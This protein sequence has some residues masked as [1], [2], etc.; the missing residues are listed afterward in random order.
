MMRKELMSLSQENR[1]SVR[2]SHSQKHLLTFQNHRLE[3]N[4]DL[5]NISHRF[6]RFDDFRNLLYYWNYF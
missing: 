5:Q 3:Q 2:V 6:K 1:Q 4:L